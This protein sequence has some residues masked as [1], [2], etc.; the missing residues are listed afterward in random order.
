MSGL[1]TVCFGRCCGV[2]ELNRHERAKQT[3]PLLAREEETGAA[4]FYSAWGFRKGASVECML[5]ICPEE[6]QCDRS[7]EVTPVIIHL[8]FSPNNR[9]VS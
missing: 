8:S 9:D 4:M 2:C 5:G 7:Q 6:Q 3:R 1:G